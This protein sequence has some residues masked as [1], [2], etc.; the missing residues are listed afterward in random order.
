MTDIFFS[1]SSRDRDRVQPVHDRL[2]AHGFDVFWD[3]SVPSGLNWDSW[4]RQHLGRA[5][6]ALVFWS[7][8]SVLSDNVVHE[9]TV[10]KQQGKL[11]PIMLDPLNAE[12]FPM[13][14]YTVQAAKLTAWTGD[15]TDAHFERLVESLEER[16]TPLWLRRRFDRLEAELVAE[17][18]RREATERRDRTLQEQISKEAGAQVDI[19]RDRDRA[20]ADNEALVAKLATM[21]ETLD[22][23]RRETAEMH[24]RMTAAEASRP[25]M[26]KPASPREENKTTGGFIKA[27]FAQPADV[28]GGALR[29]NG[30]RDLMTPPEL[31]S[32]ETLL[33]AKASRPDSDYGQE[34]WAKK[35]NLNKYLSQFP[36]GSQAVAARSELRRLEEAMAWQDVQATGK[37]AD[38]QAFLDRYPNGVYAEAARLRLRRF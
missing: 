6:C 36:N 32:A 33:W 3:Q 16:L 9:A 30:M 11:L 13:G 2:A 10:A 17:R 38:V 29:S 14:L 18:A 1:Y 7:A 20:L 37:R 31:G 27:A 22:E 12:Q 25:P 26:T 19:L 23:A 8:A 24:T 28:T 15:V 35:D 21:Q 4:I 34:L 5:K